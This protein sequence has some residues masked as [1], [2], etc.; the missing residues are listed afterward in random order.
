LADLST[1]VAVVSG[2]RIVPASRGLLL[3]LAVVALLPMA[4][5]ALFKYPLAELAGQI[6]ARLTGW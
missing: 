6:F 5:L 2:M 3:K 4:P 1:A